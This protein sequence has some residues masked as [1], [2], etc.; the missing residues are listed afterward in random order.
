M[1]VNMSAGKAVESV[2]AGLLLVFALVYRNAT[3]YTGKFGIYSYYTI[4]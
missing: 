3:K 2:D 1:G 4:D